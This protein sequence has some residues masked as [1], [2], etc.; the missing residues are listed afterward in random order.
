MA[1]N[2]GP[3]PKYSSLC[4]PPPTYL[5]VQMSKMKT[6]PEEQS[7]RGGR[8]YKPK[9]PQVPKTTKT[10]KAQNSTATVSVTITQS[11]L[12]KTLRVGNYIA[13]CEIP[14]YKISSKYVNKT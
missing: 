4:G 13:S 14:R 7:N 12:T 9:A 5:Q 11:K 10:P 6:K 8:F 2:L 3:P 1:K